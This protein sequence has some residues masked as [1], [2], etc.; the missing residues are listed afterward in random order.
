MIEASDAAVAAL[1][2][3]EFKRVVGGAWDTII[4][5]RLEDVG[6]VS[7]E[8]K[9]K[10]DRGAYL[11]MTGLV[12]REGQPPSPLF[13]EANKHGRERLPV[14]F[15]HPKE[16]WNGQ[17][18]IWVD[19][20]GK[21]AL[22][23]EGGNPA[24]PVAKLLESKFSVLAADLF[25]QGEFTPD[26]KPVAEQ[27]MIRSG[28]GGEP[29]QRAAVY[30]FGYNRPLFAQRVHDVLTL[31]RFVQTDEHEAK[32]VHLVGL[33]PVAGP[34]AAAA[35]A[36][37]GGAVNKAAIDTG[38]FRFASLTKFNDVMFVP[39]AAKYGDV[40][41]LLALNAPGKL[42]VAGEPGEVEAVKRAYGA[43]AQS[44]G[45][46][47]APSDGRADSAVDWIVRP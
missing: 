15:L 8:L 43:A 46:A 4:G 34:V 28:N 35:R 13:S 23:S 31:I 40:P 38:G 22:L 17:V 41:A 7:F 44:D 2:P 11:Q 24:A 39:G 29:W 3:D 30:T 37:S 21:S 10:T 25:G 19:G 18:V 26:A 27:R 6:A 20:N 12:T 14:L 45:I 42:W 32:Q 1:S 9:D 16:G 47:I 33:G 5:R 36:Q